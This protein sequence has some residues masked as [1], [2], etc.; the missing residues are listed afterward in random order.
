MT[1]MIS[2]SGS[3]IG[4]EEVVRHLNQTYPAAAR[5]RLR[6]TVHALG[7]ALEAKVKTEKLA[8]QVLNRRSGRL[9]RSINT[10]FDDTEQSSVATVGTNLSYGRFWELG[11]SGTETVRA[12]TRRVSSRNVRG[13][14]VTSYNDVSRKKIAQGIGYVRAH[15]RRVNVAARP[16]LRSALQDM[17]PTI[18]ASI[19]RAMQNLP[20]AN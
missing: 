1:P 6:E 12:H 16:F 19:E 3:I 5:A 17:R 18:R 4:A 7:F 11:F 8:G 15:T 10:R 20:V 9:A 2:I 14:V 13:W